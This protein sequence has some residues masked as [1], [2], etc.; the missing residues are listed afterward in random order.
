MW[1]VPALLLPVGTERDT[2]LGLRSCVVLLCLSWCTCP[3]LFLFHF[4]SCSAADE[5]LREL[6]NYEF[7]LFSPPLLCIL[8]HSCPCRVLRVWEF[9]RA[10]ETFLFFPCVLLSNLAGVGDLPSHPAGF[11]A[12]EVSLHVCV[13]HTGRPAEELLVSPEDA[14]AVWEPRRVSRG[15]LCRD[16]ARRRH[17]ARLL[18]VAGEPRGGSSSSPGWRPL[19]PRSS[20]GVG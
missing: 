18:P 10:L 12:P 9:T 17:R 6:G 3:I 19:P 4:H 13:V 16:S 11:P 2:A 1:G 5:Q 7:I 14:G 15:R 8:F 20:P